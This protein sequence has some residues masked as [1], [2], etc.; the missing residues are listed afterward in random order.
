MIVRHVRLEIRNQLVDESRLLF[1]GE[2]VL[3]LE[4]ASQVITGHKADIC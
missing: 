3:A 4:V 2:C 1:R